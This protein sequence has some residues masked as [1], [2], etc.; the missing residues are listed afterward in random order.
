M[1]QNAYGR[2]E[3]YKFT[4]WFFSCVVYPFEYGMYCILSFFMSKGAK[5]TCNEGLISQGDKINLI[6]I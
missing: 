5:C 4:T 6:T 3:H 1:M 2:E